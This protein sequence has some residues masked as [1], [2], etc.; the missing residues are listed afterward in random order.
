MSKPN[1]NNLNKG[2]KSGR[3][4]DRRPDRSDQERKVPKVDVNKP[5]PTEGTIQSHS[6]YSR[7]SVDKKITD[8]NYICTPYASANV[9]VD[10][11]AMCQQVWNKASI[12][13]N[14]LTIL[15]NQYAKTYFT[16]VDPAT[17]DD[18]ANQIETVVR[19]SAI[20]F[21]KACTCIRGF[22]SQNVKDVYG[23]SVAFLMNHYED[24]SDI[25]DPNH[26]YWSTWWD[27]EHTSEISYADVTPAKIRRD[28]IG[29]MAGLLYISPMMKS[30]CRGLFNGIVKQA[31][32]DSDTARYICFWP[33]WDTNDVSYTVM[34]NEI[35]GHCSTVRAAIAK[36]PFITNILEACGLSL[37]QAPDFY[38]IDQTQNTIDVFYDQDSMIRDTVDHLSRSVYAVADDTDLDTQQF[39]VEDNSFLRDHLM[40]PDASMPLL[41][42]VD[43][44]TF[45][46][47]MIGNL[48][49][50]EIIIAQ[51]QNRDVAE[52]GTHVAPVI[53]GFNPHPMIYDDSD[54]ADIPAVKGLIT[55]A[56]VGRSLNI[57]DLDESWV[58]KHS[59]DTASKLGIRRIEYCMS[60]ASYFLPMDFNTTVRECAY[61]AFFF[62]RLSDAKGLDTSK[63]DVMA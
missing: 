51:I 15:I 62:P 37:I 57:L 49:P 33:E 26:L 48:R 13:K 42:N 47:M 24:L 20:A 45:F 10:L 59:G 43:Y 17:T 28:I 19:Y 30:I 44:L 38:D 21:A 41:V 60:L 46:A 7:V 50:M 56:Y 18:I 39:A 40:G 2:S 16:T 36:Y 61:T 4:R 6:V 29:P 32:S 5:L 31:D 25:G 63:Q 27:Y 3:G 12:F 22:N 8:N 14:K 1:E 52:G 58:L 55:A 35:S 23:R 54:P 53:Q 9:K 11:G 34:K